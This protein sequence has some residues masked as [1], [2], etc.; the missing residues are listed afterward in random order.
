MTVCIWKNKA[1][2]SLDILISIALYY[3]TRGSLIKVGTDVRQTS[4]EPRVGKIFQ[5]KPKTWAKTA[6]KPNQVNVNEV[7]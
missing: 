2:L 7:T 6:P 3:N 1:N 5:R 4:T